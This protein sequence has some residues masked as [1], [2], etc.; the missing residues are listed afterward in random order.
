MESNLKSAAMANQAM[1][2]AMAAPPYVDQNV[3]ALKDI[4]LTETQAWEF[5]YTARRLVE[6]LFTAASELALACGGEVAVRLELKAHDAGRHT[7]SNFFAK[8]FDGT[9]LAEKAAQIVLP[10]LFLS[11]GK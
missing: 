4:G 2:E 11:E 7:G 3:Q 10:A 9:G 8:S 6:R 5:G 1:C